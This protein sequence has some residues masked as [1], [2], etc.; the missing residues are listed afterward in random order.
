MVNQDNEQR[1]LELKQEY[2]RLQ[3]DLEKLENVGGSTTQME[4]RLIE[5]EEELKKLR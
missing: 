4:K 3:G 2:V 5:I 1:I